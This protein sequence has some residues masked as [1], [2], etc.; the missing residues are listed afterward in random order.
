MA[1]RLKVLLITYRRHFYL[2]EIFK[3]LKKNNARVYVYQ[4]KPGSLKKDDDYQK[5]KKIIS[6]DKFNLGIKLYEPPKHLSSAESIKFAISRFFDENKAGLILE[7]DCIPR[8]DLRK[9]IN[10]ISKLDNNQTVYSLYDPNPLT[11][12]T[13]DIQL[14]K[15]PFL[16]VWGWYCNHYI[17]KQFNQDDNIIDIS[18]II[19][20][21][22][23]FRISSF[24]LLYWTI[25]VRLIKKRKIVSWDYDFWIFLIQND[26]QLYSLTGNLIKNVGIDDFATFSSK[27]DTRQDVFSTGKIPKKIPTTL[28]F[29]DPN[30]VCKFHYKVNFIRIVILFLIWIKSH[31]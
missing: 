31:V 12:S 20:H 7:D 9:F 27:L 22:K 21:L 23:S 5:V 4:N 3:I 30:I 17:W 1:N 29:I 28:N 26:I 6:E 2:N 15:T 10:L 24:N 16:H 14:T 11:Q 8:E 19:L 25:L 18:K 13:A